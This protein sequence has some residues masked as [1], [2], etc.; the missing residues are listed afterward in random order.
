[1]KHHRI[2]NASAAARDYFR[3]C[4]RLCVVVCLVCAFPLDLATARQRVGDTPSP[5]RAETPEEVATFS[6]LRRNVFSMCMYCHASVPGVSFAT[7]HD[8]LK[9]VMPG[10]PEQSR[11][12]IMI[13]SKRM[14]KGRGGLP[15]EQLRAIRD[16]IANGAKDD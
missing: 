13:E 12:Y 2:D 11:L 14:P 15:E 9:H 3:H 10:A 6:W 4:G 7:H 8:T 1:M 5:L 16:W